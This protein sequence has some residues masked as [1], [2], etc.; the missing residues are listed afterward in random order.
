MIK[1][2]AVAS[3]A[4]H[5]RLP[6]YEIIRSIGKG[7]M[8]EIF[9]GIRQGP[10]GFRKPVALKRL[11]V[12]GGMNPQALERFLREARI[13]ARLNH[14]NIVQT[15]DLLSVDGDYYLVMELLR[16]HDLRELCRLLPE[17]M[18]AWAA[19]SIADQ[20]L[21]GLEYAHNLTDAET[22]HPLGLVHR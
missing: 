6:G 10:K 20:V 22:G 11:V 19:L 16:G 13:C 5:A 17:P 15:Y 1:S 21:A 2:C 12:D 9:E 18:P 4:T 7:G 3:S 8:G 14:A